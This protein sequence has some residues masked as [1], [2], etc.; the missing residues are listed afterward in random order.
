MNVSPRNTK[1]FTQ[2][3]FVFEQ[4]VFSSKSKNQ[5]SSDNI[6][7]FEFV[8]KAY[9]PGKLCFRINTCSMHS[10]IHK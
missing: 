1:R 5:R 3:S 6:H 7:R 4:D 9:M 10:Y 2:N 8:L